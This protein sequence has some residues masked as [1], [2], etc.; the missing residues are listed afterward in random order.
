[1]WRSLWKLHVPTKIKVFVWLALHDILPTRENLVCQRIV[2]DGTCEL[3][4]RENESVLHA[5]WECSAGVW[6]GCSRELQKH[7]SGQTDLMQ[8]FEAISGSL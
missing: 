6:A 7:V 3:Y 2:A 1:M 4:Q 5:L 8:L